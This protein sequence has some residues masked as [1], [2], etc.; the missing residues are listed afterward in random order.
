MPAAEEL[1]AQSSELLTVVGSL[2][3][4]VNGDKHAPR[5]KAAR[6]KAKS[7][8]KPK[9]AKKAAQAAK[10]EVKPAAP[11]PHPAPVKG[12]TESGKKLTPSQIIPLDESD[13]AGF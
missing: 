9:F 13:F 2:T 1:N 6:A 11:A 4:M 8:D 3:H 12:N 5:A 10:A 7:P